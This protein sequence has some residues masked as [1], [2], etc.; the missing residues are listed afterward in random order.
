M[1]EDTIH[2]CDHPDCEGKYHVAC[3][4]YWMT[5]KWT[6]P[7]KLKSGL[8]KCADNSY[9]TQDKDKVTCEACKSRMN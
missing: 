7:E 1:S 8:C 9:L 6:E 2:Y 3:R 5:T 4:T